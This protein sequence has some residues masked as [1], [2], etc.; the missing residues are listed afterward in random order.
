MS[1]QIVEIQE[2]QLPKQ[3]H[4]FWL[5]A[6]SAVE[7]KNYSYAVSLC[8]GVLKDAPGFVDARK[9]ARRCAMKEVGVQ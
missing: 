8:H 3:A 5:K 7:L 4:T 1:E 6:L 2:N 9:L